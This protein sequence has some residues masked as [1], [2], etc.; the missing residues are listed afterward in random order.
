MYVFDRPNTNNNTNSTNLQSKLTVYDVHR[1]IREK[2]I[3]RMVPYET[4]LARAHAHVRRSA[5]AGAVSCIVEIPEYIPGLPIIDLNTCV[6]FI[7]SDLTRGGFKVKYYF[8]RYLYVSWDQADVV[9]KDAQMLAD[10]LAT[11]PITLPPRPPPPPRIP[12]FVPPPPMQHPQQQRPLVAVPIHVPT[13]IQMHQQ[14]PHTFGGLSSKT[15]E[16]ALE[17]PT[18]PRNADLD[19]FFAPMSTMD[20]RPPPPIALPPAPLALP[21]P[22]RTHDI[23]EH[24]QDHVQMFDDLPRESVA[25]SNRTTLDALFK[26]K[27]SGK[28]AVSL[29]I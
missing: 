9:K 22:S 27:K 7:V 3:R 8:P 19:A 17:P 11:E 10:A 18:Q 12:I 26:T 14:P 24:Q 20:F 25:T 2:R 15:V 13:V 23:H 6:P 29:E 16:Y 4:V 28:L 5:E 21:E 1:T